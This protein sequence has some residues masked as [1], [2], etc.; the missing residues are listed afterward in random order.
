MRIIGNSCDDIEMC[1]KPTSRASSPIASS[2]S[3]YVNLRSKPSSAL[4]WQS[5][6]RV[7]ENDGDRAVTLSIQPEGRP[8][9]TSLSRAWSTWTASPLMPP[10]DLPFTETVLAPWAGVRA[11]DPARGVKTAPHGHA[12]PVGSVPYKGDPLVNLD[13]IAVQMRSLLDW[14]SK[15]RGRA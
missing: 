9:T 12:V 1:S 13:D 2:C 5:D 7:S 11:G 4:T 8:L 3:G 6:V 15:I 10:D 14:R